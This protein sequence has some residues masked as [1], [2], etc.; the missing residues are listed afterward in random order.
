MEDLKRFIHLSEDG[1]FLNLTEDCN[2]SDYIFRNGRLKHLQIV[3]DVAELLESISTNITSVHFVAKDK[4][5]SLQI[6]CVF[7]GKKT[8]QFCAS[9]PNLE[10]LTFIVQCLN[11]NPGE[12]N[13]DDWSE[14]A[15]SLTNLKVVTIFVRPLRNMYSP[16]RAMF[17]KQIQIKDK[18]LPCAS[19]LLEH[20]AN[21]K[22]ICYRF[23]NIPGTWNCG[24]VQNDLVKFK[25]NLQNQKHDWKFTCAMQFLGQ[26][27]SYE[28]KKDGDGD[29]ST[30]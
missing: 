8:L 2:S 20:S 13:T 10:A 27:Y 26:R 7:I 28:I 24:T 22:V 19:I 5:K 15:K 4:I 1:I 12:F 9:F 29:A 14:L 11:G 6:Q 17:S 3:N 23:D 30:Q 25:E 21:L 16:D 18:T